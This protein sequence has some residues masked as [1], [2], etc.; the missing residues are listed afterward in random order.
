M[1]NRTLKADPVDLV[2]C[3]RYDKIEDGNFRPDAETES[4]IT[5][6]EGHLQKRE[7]Y[8]YASINFCNCGSAYEHGPSITV[9]PEQVRYLDVDR[10]TIDT[11]LTRHV[12]ERANSARRD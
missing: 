1:Q 12:A 11:L 10:A 9:L 2:V 5:D 4:I 8:P 3:G 6:L 7:L